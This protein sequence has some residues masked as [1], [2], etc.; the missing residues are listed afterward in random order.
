[1][2]RK[3][4]KIL[5]SALFSVLFVAVNLIFIRSDNY[6]FFAFPLAFIALL[7][8]V[9]AQEY[10]YWAILFLT[11]LSV[12]LDVL[13]L[14]SDIALPTEP[15]LFAL[16]VF[17][18]LKL[19][20]KGKA[21]TFML[22]HPISLAVVFYLFWMLVSSITSEDSLVS[23]KFLLAHLWFV[24]PLYFM[25]YPLYKKTKNINRFFWLSL[26]SL[27]LV[28]IYTT[29]IHASYGFSEEVGRWV[30]SPFYND[31][32]AYGMILAFFI[33]ILLGFVFWSKNSFSLRLFS[34]VLG[35]LFLF[36][37]YLSYSRAAWLSLFVAG[38]VYAFMKLKVRFAYLLLFSFVVLAL[39]VI[40]L[41]QI[42]ARLEMNKVQSSSNFVEHVESSSNIAS[43]ASNLE[44]INRWNC[45][46]R[47]FEKR[48]FVG[49]GPGTYQFVYG[50]M[51]RSDERTIISTNSGDAGTAH[52]EYL[53]PLAE[54]GFLGLIAILAVFL[55]MMATGFKVYRK[56]K[57]SE[58]KH[59]ALVVTLAL[60][61]YLSHA[62]L[63]NFLDTD[64]AAVPFWTL[65]AILL[66]L[67]RKSQQ[68][69]RLD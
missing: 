41:D 35:V 49:W 56:S 36:A 44:R 17:F 51:Q 54:S 4:W 8:L 6:Y 12:N 52:S 7:L 15:L 13:E 24:L 25:A 30:M 3:N 19:F 26:L 37:F 45:A 34:A 61:T 18:L 10:I 32:T 29:F 68:E 53:G 33:P 28:V 23:F 22:K 9:F 5:L 60:S 69:E 59:L 1:M 38:V 20:R 66:A 42:R 64:K 48:K 16:M 40:N 50:P 2:I 21:D 31:H 11:P 46:L 14:G 57:S 43:D 58:L 39:V 67:D 63:N 55:S 27:S 47:L 62:F 65:A